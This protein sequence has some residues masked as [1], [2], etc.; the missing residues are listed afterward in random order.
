M[1][2]GYLG[3][4]NLREVGRVHNYTKEQIDEIVK[5]A[6]DPIYFIMTYVKVISL[7]KGMIPFELYDFQ[8]ELINLIHGNRFVIG[9]MARQSGK[10]TTV[11]AYFLW[12]ILFNEY[13]NIAILANKADTARE[14]LGKV[15]EAYEYLPIWL[16]QGIQTWNKGS[17]EIENGSRIK[18]TATSASAIRGQSMNIIFLDEF[19]HIHNNLAEEFYTSVYPVISSGKTTKLF[20]VSTPKGM[21]LFHKLW[22]EAENGKSNF[23]TFEAHWTA[24]PG[25]D[26]AW[27]AQ[28]I[29]NTS[30]E[31]FDQEFDCSFIGSTGTLINPK[32]LRTLVTK[33][34]ES[35]P[36]GVDVYERPIDGHKY[37]IT[38]DSAEGKGQDYHAL[39]VFDV[40]QIPY[41][42]VCKFRNRNMAYLELPSLVYTLAKNYN[43]AHILVEVQS[44]G[45]QVVD[46][47]H[48][49]LEY[50]NIIHVVNKG[51]AGQ[52]VASG[53]QK[54]PQRGVKASKATKKIGCLNLKSLI[55]TDKLIIHDHD[56]IAELTTFVTDDQTYNA[57]PGCH[58][59]MVMTLILFSWLVAQKYFKE[60]TG[61]EGN[62][63][64]NTMESSKKKFEDDFTPFGIIFNMI[65][66]DE[67]HYVTNDGTVWEVI[68]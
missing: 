36:N 57:E 27:K 18:A 64:Q 8:Q 17:I 28:T 39:S 30:E 19:A 34:P 24:V 32:K 41:K 67:E 42:H 26:D 56:T 38:L 48:Y 44:T 15:K 63:H 7:D 50:E 45:Q 65:P 52:V 33:T 16:Q 37:V 68:G 21:N 60:G 62:I 23:K 49:D 22:V 59:D 66:N 40:T 13:V 4:P 54:N 53:Y 55:E 11:V 6:N 1:K 51:K 47:I 20:I 9:K 12:Y 10:S 46:L 2:Q 5:C 3:N 14:L 43:N 35:V 58:D 61:V 31:Q 25:R 29:A